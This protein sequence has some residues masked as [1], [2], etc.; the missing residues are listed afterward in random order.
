VTTVVDQPGESK[1]FKSLVQVAVEI[2][3]GDHA[4]PSVFRGCL[5]TSSG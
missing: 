3:D 5:G 2:A 1:H 4:R